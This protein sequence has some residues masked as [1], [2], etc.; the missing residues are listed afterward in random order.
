MPVPADTSSKCRSAQV[1]LSEA[2]ELALRDADVGAF[3]LKEFG[4]YQ[5]KG[6]RNP[7]FSMSLWCPVCRRDE[8]ET[9]VP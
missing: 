3:S 5:L 1:L 4:T 8:A 2:A 7:S 6:F 9:R